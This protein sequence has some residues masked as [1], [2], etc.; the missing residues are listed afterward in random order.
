M[1]PNTSKKTT[2]VHCLNSHKCHNNHYTQD[3]SN[4]TNEEQSCQNSTI[5]TIY[6]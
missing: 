6:Y 4:K 1:L 3:G 2:T 5:D